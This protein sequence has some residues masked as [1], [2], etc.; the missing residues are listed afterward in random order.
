M[1]V[2]ERFKSWSDES[3]ESCDGS[4]E[5]FKKVFGIEREMTLFCG[6]HVMPCHEHGVGEDEFHVDKIGD[7]SLER[8]S[9]EV[10]RESKA[11]PSGDTAVT[12]G[13]WWLKW[14]RI[15]KVKKIE[16]LCILMCLKVVG[17]WEMLNMKW[18]LNL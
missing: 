16:T 1:L 9:P 10:R 4:E 11:S 8:E 17:W 18:V 5:R 7:E 3:D 14:W 2:D 12:G 15:K 13:G 6:E